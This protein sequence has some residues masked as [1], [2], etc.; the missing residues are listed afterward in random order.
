[1]T[2]L[3]SLLAI[4]PA[5]AAGSA[6][7]MAKD[8]SSI[9]R[10]TAITVF[11]RLGAD[12]RARVEPLLRDSDRLVRQQAHQTLYQLSDATRDPAARRAAARE[13]L[14]SSDAMA[15]AAALRG[16]AAWGD[17]TDLAL[18]LTAFDRASHDSVLVASSAAIAAVGANQRR[19]GKGADAFFARY[20]QRPTNPVV[21]RDAD[22]ALGDAA[23]RA[24]GPLKPLDAGR[25]EQEYRRLVERWVVP[26]YNGAP[27]PRAR[28]ETS[29][30]SMELELYPGD[31]PIAVDDFVKAVQSGAIIG[32]EFGRVVPDFVDQQ[33]ALHD[34]VEVRDE[35]NRHRLARANL[36]WATA[37][38]DTGRP[39]YTLGI[40]WQPHNEGDFTSMGRVVRGMDVVERIELGDRIT[41]AVMLGKR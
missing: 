19:T 26:D 32:V 21:R 14:E 16:I 37:G 11:G 41:G 1:V 40:T 27:R 8:T 9:C 15:R 12:G 2:A 25:T 23:R 24:W 22:R 5:A 7:A 39:G 13:A 20:S 3:Q 33:R 28:W 4:S 6:D 34:D 31:T 10:L 30:G 36:A 18:V 29:R 17:T 35:V 38:L